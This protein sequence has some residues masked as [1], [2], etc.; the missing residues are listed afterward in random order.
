MFSSTLARRE[1][2][3]PRHH[4]INLTAKRTNAPEQR[5]ENIT[6]GK[7][8]K[9][10]VGSEMVKQGKYY[11]F[12]W[13]GS[14][15]GPALYTEKTH[16]QGDTLRWGRKRTMKKNMNLRK[17][18]KIGKSVSYFTLSLSSLPLFPESRHSP[19][20]LP[21]CLVPRTPNLWSNQENMFL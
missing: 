11:T 2:L 3:H 18:V 6:A 1:V 17:K 20:S 12:A 15:E 5:H 19:P 8:R 14:C 10:R 16:T 9:T 7:G 21:R 4:I 13:C